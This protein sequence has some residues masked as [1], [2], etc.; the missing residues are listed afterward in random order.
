MPVTCCHSALMEEL[1]VC[2][3]KVLDWP[4]RVIF[5]WLITESALFNSFTPHACDYITTEDNRDSDI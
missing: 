4:D 2:R 5:F 1:Q 3:A